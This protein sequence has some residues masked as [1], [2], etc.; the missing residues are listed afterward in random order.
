MAFESSFL[1]QNFGT[2]C[3]IQ[4]GAQISLLVLVVLEI[5]RQY[6]DNWYVITIQTSQT[7]GTEFHVPI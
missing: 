1:S 3:S 6:K 4:V 5:T 7:H 2:V